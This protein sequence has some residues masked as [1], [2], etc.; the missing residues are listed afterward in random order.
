MGRHVRG[1]RRIGI[2]RGIRRR[3]EQTRHPG[4]C[5]SR[6]QRR[7]RMPGQYE[8]VASSEDW[9]EWLRTRS[10]SVTATDIARLA[11][12]GPAVWA[13]IRA[14]KQGHRSFHGNKYT[15]WGKARERS[16]EHTSE[17]QSRGQLVCRLLLEK[18][19]QRG[20]ADTTFNHHD[21]ERTR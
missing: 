12:G 3:R 14:E 9:D 17:L 4:G 15:E 18:K 13:T 16:E 5:L 8:A 20:R 1:H 7:C 2:R 6:F 19:T 11:A 10:S 21:G